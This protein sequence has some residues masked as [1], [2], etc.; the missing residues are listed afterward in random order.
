MRTARSFSG[1]PTATCSGGV[2]VFGILACGMTLVIITGGIDL[3][4][5]SILGVCAVV[6]SLLSMHMGQPACVA[7]GITLA[8]GLACGVLSRAASSPA[9]ASN[10]LSRRWR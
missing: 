4:V 7:I 2:S 1:I 10:R 9:S 3:S 5:G 8:L 6:F